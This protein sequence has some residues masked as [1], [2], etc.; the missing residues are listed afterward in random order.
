M[1]ESLPAERPKTQDEHAAEFNV[2][3]AKV[4][5]LWVENRAQGGMTKEEALSQ[6]IEG[7]LGERFRGFVEHMPEDFSRVTPEE[8][9]ASFLSVINPEISRKAA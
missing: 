2:F 3:Q 6:W 7:K 1:Q 9:F 5:K 4:M 8:V